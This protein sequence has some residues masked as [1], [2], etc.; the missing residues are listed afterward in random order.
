LEYVVEIPGERPQVV[1]RDLVDVVGEGRRLS[2]DRGPV[3]VDGTDVLRRGLALIGWTDI[4]PTVSWLQQGFVQHLLLSNFTDNVEP[5]Q[6]LMNDM[7]VDSSGS[8]PSAS[9]GAADLNLL[10]ANLYMYQLLRSTVSEHR[11]EVF[12]DRPNLVSA[13][14]QASMRDGRIGFRQSLDV[15]LNDVSVLP[16]NPDPR[17]TRLAQGVLDTI[18]EV[19][20]GGMASGESFTTLVQ[21]TNAA[22]ALFVSRQHGQEWKAVVEA[23]DAR[24]TGGYFDGDTV[25]RVRA[26]LE[27]GHVAYV[28]AGGPDD[29]RNG[30]AAWW[31][32]DPET[33]QALGIGPRGW[34]QDDTGEIVL[35]QGGVKALL[36][37]MAGGTARA[38]VFCAFAGATAVTLYAIGWTVATTNFPAAGGV[39]A[40]V[41]V[42]YIGPK[43]V[44]GLVFRHCIE[45]MLF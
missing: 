14:T 36:M 17:R 29:P 18:L 45:A 25:G 27:R 4:L 15:V 1:R 40:F 10:P 5:A 28:P 8:A 21:P 22:S 44:F 13:H 3:E 7:L 30:L 42:A 34:G 2:P 20:V 35:F 26:A 16:G 39:A 11:D 32:V 38:T 19:V 31:D 12:Q 43:E 23:N 6:G 24:L 33:G 41:I 37:G 9:G